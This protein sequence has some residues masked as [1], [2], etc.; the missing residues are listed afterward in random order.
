MVDMVDDLGRCP[1]GGT[2]VL[3]H[4]GPCHNFAAVPGLPG[5]P[6]FLA[7]ILILGEPVI[8]RGYPV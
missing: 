3:Q 8:N 5:A 6:L 7:P 2:G 4:K 1:F